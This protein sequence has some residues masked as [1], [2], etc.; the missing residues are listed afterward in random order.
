MYCSERMIF[1]LRGKRTLRH[2]YRFSA[3]RKLY[4]LR[5][6][7]SSVHVITSYSFRPCKKR[8]I[9]GRIDKSN[10]RV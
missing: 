8:Q 9:F 5:T 4:L 7:G 2:M 6:S 3:G 10:F 1:K